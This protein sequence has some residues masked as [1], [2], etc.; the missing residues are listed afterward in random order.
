MESRWCP[1][2]RTYGRVGSRAAR[3]VLLLHCSTMSTEYERVNRA[4]A[5][6]CIYPLPSPP[7][8]SP[9]SLSS[10]NGTECNNGMCG[11][12]PVRL[13]PLPGCPL[14][15]TPCDGADSKKTIAVQNE[16]FFF[17][18]HIT[19]NVVITAPCPLSSVAKYVLFPTHF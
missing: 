5:P 12:T 2:E 19:Y 13:P 18:S 17:Q 4:T 7:S 8:P 15:L 16:H 6:V 1:T 3:L 9:S 10:I 11:P 14:S